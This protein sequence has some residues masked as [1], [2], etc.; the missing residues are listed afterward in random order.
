MIKAI[1]SAVTANKIMFKRKVAPKTLYLTF[2]DGPSQM[3][4]PAVLDLLKK[5]QIQ[6]TF[7]FVGR[8]VVERPD[9][10]HR[11]VREGHSLGNHSIIHPRMDFLSNEARLREIRGMDRLL[12][13]FDQRAKHL[14]RPPYGKVSLSLFSFCLL[15][16]FNV[17]MWSRDS[18]DYK[19]NAEEVTSGLM[20]KPVSDGD[21]ILFHDDGAACVDA[22]TKL[23]PIWKAEGYR[24]GLLVGENS[25]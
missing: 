24:F 11:T 2:D 25:H 1:L 9:I 19:G 18:M 14:F 21:I 17:A 4:T 3:H 8:E 6:A 7:F 10:V 22:L 23:L 15:N 16:D 5:H 12:S 13:E 20:N